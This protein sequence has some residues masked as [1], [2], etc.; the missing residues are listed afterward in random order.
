MI[1]LIKQWFAPPVVEEDE[2]TL[3]VTL[4]NAVTIT[5]L[6]FSSLILLDSLIGGKPPLITSLINIFAFAVGIMSRRWLRLGK[7]AL[8]GIWMLIFGFLIITGEIASLGTLRTPATTVYLLLVVLA[9]VLFAFRGVMIT[10]IMSSLSVL[11]FMLAENAGMLPKPDASVTIMHWTAYTGLFA[12]AGAMVLFTL[13]ITRRALARAT[14]EIIERRYTEMALKESQTR[15]Q[16]LAD[17]TIQSF[18]LMDRDGRVR[19][20]NR[21]AAQSA[22][23]L[24]GLDIREG[25]PRTKF[26]IKGNSLGFNDNFQK[27]LKGEVITSENF[28]HAPNGQEVWLSFTYTPTHDEDGNISGVCLNV[29]DITE[30][31]KVEEKL[32]RQNEYLSN[33]HQITV[34]LLSRQKTQTLL[35]NIVHKAMLL[36][37]AHHGYVFLPDGDSLLLSAATPGFAHHIGRREPQPGK[38]VLGLVW[39]GGEIVVVENY[40]DWEFRDPAYEQDGLLAIAG[41]PIKT[42]DDI[43]GVL[44]VV[45]TKSPRV[46]TDE[47]LK[48]LTRFATLAALVLDNARLLDATE[49]EIAERKR[50]EAVLQR[51]VNE[52]EQLQ[53]ELR[54]QALRDPL[55][56]LYNRRYLDE[57]IQ[58][59]ISKAKRENKPLSIIVSDIDHFKSINDSY[60]HQVGDRFLVEIA[61]LMKANARSSDIVCRYGGE[62]FL[63]VLPGATLSSALKRA[64]ELLQKCTGTIISHEG[65]GLRVGMSLGVATFPDHGQEAKELITKADKALYISKQNGRNQVNPWVE[66]LEIKN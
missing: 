43:I 61:N 40:S 22:S 48:I 53:A 19:F 52:I 42:G 21:A 9:G 41:V 5:I 33:L 35:N 16:A 36:V 27:A 44:E 1:A 32:R 25:D 46:F 39:Q 29:I 45:N 63:L 14:N 60:G 37:N 66:N 20:Y 12:I 3:H 17:S 55:T 51:H 34:D 62:E 65:Q 31:Q 38:G 2:K 7:N 59:E 6:V 11:G 50:N 15:L 18:M 58:R 49:H 54:E 47:E 4:L 30:R 28:L 56:G 23:L 26:I 10:T 64:R 24:L 8:V 57:T 13:Q